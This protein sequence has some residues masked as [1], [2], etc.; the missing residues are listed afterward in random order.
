M[1][2]PRH[3][4]ATV[5]LFSF[6][7][8]GY[9][10]LGLEFPSLSDDFEGPP[11][12]NKPDSLVWGPNFN[13]DVL[14]DLRRT[15]KSKRYARSSAESQREQIVAFMAEVNGDSNHNRAYLESRKNREVPVMS[16]SS[17]QDEHI[18]A[19]MAKTQ[20]DGKRDK[21]QVRHQAALKNKRQ[22]FSKDK[23]VR[24]NVADHNDVSKNGPNSK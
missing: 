24:K 20:N 10:F 3:L 12:R 23:S 4:L 19:K 17:S 9:C 1:I 22:G 5:L 11:P 13:Q 15:V 2:F 18:E 16:N 14:D 8:H 21:R 7:D 6:L